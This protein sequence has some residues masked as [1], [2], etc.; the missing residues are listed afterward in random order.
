MK[1]HDKHFLVGCGIFEMLRRLL[2][3]FRQ[4]NSGTKSS[5]KIA[6]G[7]GT[8]NSSGAD[9]SIDNAG[10]RVRQTNQCGGSVAFHS[11]GSGKK[12]AAARALGRHERLAE[13]K[14]A[15]WS[16]L[17]FLFVQACSSDDDSDA[18]CNCRIS[19]LESVF[20]VMLD[21]LR[22]SVLEY[23]DKVVNVEMRMKSG[24]HTGI[25]LQMGQQRSPDENSKKSALQKKKQT[26]KRSQ[27]LIG[28][29]RR[30][31][32][33]DGVKIPSNHLI[34]NAKGDDFSV[35]FWVN[36]SQDAT[37]KHRS[38]IV[39]GY[40]NER[41]PLVLLRPND[42]KIEV[43]H[44]VTSPLLVSN[45]AIPLNVWTHVALVSDA[46]KLKLFYNGS[47]DCQRSHAIFSPN[48]S[49][50]A[51]HI[52]KVP[53]D[54]VQLD[55]VIGGFEGT[56]ANLRFFSRALSPI[57]VRIV[58]D[59]GPPETC[60]ASDSTCYQMCTCL[61]L[62]CE[63]SAGANILSS[64]KWLNIL[65]Y[66]FVHGTSRMQQAVVRIWSILLP[67]VDPEKMDTLSLNI[68]EDENVDNNEVNETAKGDD[69]M[70]GGIF[71][72]YLFRLVGLS[73]W[74]QDNDGGERDE[75]GGKGG[76][77]MKGTSSQDKLFLRNCMSTFAD[78]LLHCPSSVRSCCEPGG[79]QNS[80]TRSI[81]AVESGEN[82]SNVNHA[83]KNADCGVGSG[84][85]EQ[86]TRPFFDTQLLLPSKTLDDLS[87]LSS[88][89]VFLCQKLFGQ[90]KNWN[91]TLCNTMRNIMG[92]K[93]KF[94]VD[95]FL[96]SCSNPLIG[97]E[98]IA[99][100]LIL[101][102]HAERLR[103]GI[104][105]QLAHTDV[106][107][108]MINFCQNRKF[109]QV[110]L[111]N[112]ENEIHLD[113][114]QP[115]AP[116]AAEDKSSDVN[117][118]ASSLLKINVENVSVHHRHDCAR[119]I[120]DWS[121]IKESKLMEELVFPL[122]MQFLSNPSNCESGDVE[123]DKEEN[124]LKDRGHEDS[125]KGVEET[126]T[127]LEVGDDDTSFSEDFQN[128]KS[129][130]E[131]KVIINKQQSRQNLVFD[132][133]KFHQIRSTFTQ[134]LYKL[135]L[136][137]AWA[138]ILCEIPGL[139]QNI[140][141]LSVTAADEGSRT[142]T[143]LDEVEHQVFSLKRR[144]FQNNSLEKQENAMEKICRSMS[145]ATRIK[146]RHGAVLD[147]LDNSTASSFNNDEDT[148]IVKQVKLT[149]PICNCECSLDGEL[150][151][152]V[153]ELH[154]DTR[155]KHCCPICFYKNGDSTL[156]Q[157]ASHIDNCH[158]FHL[159]S[160]ENIESA[161]D[162]GDN[163]YEQREQQLVHQEQQQQQHI[164]DNNDICSPIEQLMDMGFRREWCELAL[165]ETG[166]DVEYAS[167]WIVDNLDFLGSMQPGVSLMNEIELTR[168]QVMDLEE[169][170]NIVS[171]I[172]STNEEVIVEES[173]ED[174][175]A[176]K[177]MKENA[178]KCNNDDLS[179]SSNTIARERER[180]RGEANRSEGRLL[181]DYAA[182]EEIKN[183]VQS[184][185]TDDV[186]N[187]RAQL[188]DNLEAEGARS[189]YNENYFTKCLH[190]E[191]MLD[192]EFRT[193]FGAN[194]DSEPIADGG[195]DRGKIAGEC[196]EENESGSQYAKKKLVEYEYEMTNLDLTSLFDCYLQSEK[197]LAILHSRAILLQLLQEK[198]N[199]KIDGLKNDDDGDED[200]QIDDVFGSAS[201]FVHALKVTC[202]RG[203][204]FPVIEKQNEGIFTHDS[205][206]DLGTN[207]TTLMLLQSP[208]II[209]EKF[210]VSEILAR[211]GGVTTFSF[212]VLHSCLEDVEA[213]A[214]IDSFSDMMWG[215]RNLSA[216]DSQ[217]LLQPNLELA[218]WL[219]TLLLD[220][221]IQIMYTRSTF[222]RLSACLMSANM[223]IKEAVMHL[224]WRVVV[225]WIEC[226]KTKTD[227]LR[228][229][230]ATFENSTGDFGTSSSNNDSNDDSNSNSPPTPNEMRQLIN[231]FIPLGRMKRIANQRAS[232]ERRQERIFV[233]VYTKKM[234]NLVIAVC[235]LFDNIDQHNKVVT[236]QTKIEE[237][238][239]A[240]VQ[241][242]QMTIL[243]ENAISV[244]WDRP[245]GYV[246]CARYE[247]ELATNT[248]LNDAQDKLRFIN[249]YSG[250]DEECLV[251]N[252]L[253]L[254]QYYCRA[255]A[256]SATGIRGEWCEPV[257]EKSAP[258]IAF[259]FD[260]A[261]SGPNIFVSTD[262]LSASFG[263][264]EN[265]ST[266][267]G[268]TP[269]ISGRNCWEIRVDKSQTAYLF[270]GV[271]TKHADTA[272]FLG[273]DD[274]GWG[275]IG[276]RA[277]YHKRSKVK[278]FGERFGQGDVIGVC[279]DLDKGTL[280]FSR[281]G[282]EM[283]VAFDG[284]TGELFPAVAFYNQGQRVS[285]VRG[286]F[287]CPEAGLVVE[288]S[289]GSCDL[290]NVRSFFKLMGLIKTME[291]SNVWRKDENAKMLATVFN[292]FCVW[293]TGTG[294]RHMT[295]CGFELMFD[296]SEDALEKYGVKGDEIISCGRGN[297]RVVGVSNGMLWIHVD[298]ENGAWFVRDSE[299]IEQKGKFGYFVTTAR[300]EGNE[301]DKEFDPGMT[302]IEI[303][304]GV[305][306]TAEANGRE[307]GEEEKIPRI[308][309]DEFAEILGGDTW[310][311][312]MDGTIV[313]SVNEFC[314]RY[315]LSPWNLTLQLLHQAISPV[316]RWLS[317]LAGRAIRDLEINCRYCVIMHFNSL[318]V[319]AIYFVGSG[320]TSVMDCGELRGGGG[321]GGGGGECRNGRFG[322]FA[323]KQHLLRHQEANRQQLA[324]KNGYSSEE[325]G[326][327]VRLPRGPTS[328]SAK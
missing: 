110:L 37:G 100:L 244:C 219:L 75:G 281:N 203:K 124:C 196:V 206:R 166:N 238:F 39:R 276:D 20:N 143:T 14:V 293:S 194:V 65:F 253:P 235:D 324:G 308:S 130:Q 326:R 292:T 57:H 172:A 181:T 230:L 294:L 240:I 42:R 220:N 8:A 97:S 113:A 146:N 94:S 160:E 63:S 164:N 68:S 117:N 153:L 101:G 173:E 298:G 242:L 305:G 236:A 185:D 50:H 66:L 257:V 132:S 168:E 18:I 136:D 41:W 303:G 218:L 162:G 152:H 73:V 45:S 90:S 295:L 316:K 102:G 232:E 22:D 252:L 263:S 310:S 122:A 92:G 138:S 243:S 273:G 296:R 248:N 299:I 198:N 106:S 116:N 46:N 16:L 111:N 1:F 188:V 190:G 216:S 286:G 297:A 133:I 313:K 289:P 156:F 56:L 291:N 202:F 221:K 86:A 171:V 145:F 161:N 306:K 272:T 13:G 154:G 49:R 323:E 77:E 321:G 84:T 195:P 81:K 10:E 107:A 96:E 53:K 319:N 28:A 128:G 174:T 197:I 120:S 127:T 270:I 72:K 210:L 62:V 59:E 131:A 163:Q 15:I 137:G 327:R 246:S 165:R 27:E 189:V 267:M 304:S 147:A 180:E 177:E 38:L 149:C 121:I 167:T 114:P 233:S 225:G 223:P 231:N 89:I 115:I 204:Q 34:Q 17:R 85:G 104:P 21:E 87:T 9:E 32:Q 179:A 11:R 151:E 307:R 30:F 322:Q 29:P 277:L 108:T 112:T 222:Q 40:K 309:I 283:G 126:P 302:C 265:W 261:N 129:L 25:D 300:G 284:L 315:Q 278:V 91:R 55:G 76:V 317:E 134:M 279:L 184:N 48:R 301:G 60:S 251:E 193:S 43:G 280:S 141:S 290:D 148:T 5:T 213:A 217:A 271:A 227:K 260:R 159:L 88:E 7:A 320:G 157:L 6:S 234:T 140:T 155:S 199:K 311:I 51:L 123:S 258:G 93:I 33:E 224:L 211:R 61:Y 58:C 36:L 142:F 214:S 109:T 191:F 262:G 328:S 266:V 80:G 176:E 170:A 64:K 35:A 178:E 54:S 99:S 318:L 169:S 125:K 23:T 268:S 69:D 98:R 264:N 287:H 44:S 83:N 237:T 135:S 78:F 2:L 207:S 285:L 312:E 12:V 228:D 314:E 79:V 3:V 95:T 47:C 226:V 139:L 119:G 200:S 229:N 105:V 256:I 175:A 215:A 269:F 255:R 144:L 201:A 249:I 67:T 26:I 209:F 186:E 325:S 205:A 245:A 183:L 31:G 288:G 247:V 254:R 192:V 4:M 19:G 250:H 187:H 52:G 158:L 274:F 282:E 74:R 24:N 150:A 208:T 70:G 103:P 259:T 239:S 71:Q 118:V 241:N 82:V 182:N 212:T 275:Y